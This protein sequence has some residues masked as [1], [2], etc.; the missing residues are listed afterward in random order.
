MMGVVVEAALTPSRGARRSRWFRAVRTPLVALGLLLALWRLAP[1]HPIVSPWMAIVDEKSPIIGTV[2]T[3]IFL[4]ALPFLVL[5]VMI[6]G[7]IHVW[8]SD[9]ALQKWMP[10]RRVP[11]AIVGSLLGLIL[12]VCECG[13]IAV[14]RR[15]LSRGAP[16][17]L[18]L[19]FMLAGPVVNPVVLGSTWMA[20]GDDAIVIVGRFGLILAAAIGVAILFSLHLQP[21]AL[22]MSVVPSAAVCKC[23]SNSP[24]DRRFERL[25]LVATDELFE[26]GAYLVIGGLAAA[27]VQAVVPRTFF[28][29]IVDQPGLSVLALMALAMILSVC[30]AVDAFVALSFV[31]ALGPGPIVAFLVFG[32]MVSLKNLLMY[33]SVLRPRAVILLFVVSAQLVFLGA[34]LISL[35]HG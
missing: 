2:F 34:S 17:P 27:I 5:G 8:V 32:P 6:S 26:M 14:G 31:S 15:L 28:V 9:T 3:G 18:V 19:A 30:S 35:L 7:A 10:A 25:L 13:V 29:A 24:G 20:F 16:V 12:P 33:T 11:S 22:L 23:P 4:E 1:A 21:E